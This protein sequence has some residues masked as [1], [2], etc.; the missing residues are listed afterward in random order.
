MKRLLLLIALAVF[1]AAS[2][3]AGPALRVDAAA[4][5][6]SP[7]NYNHYLA[8]SMCQSV[9]N[10]YEGIM[11][12]ED[13]KAAYP[14]IEQ[15]GIRFKTALC[16][17]GPEPKTLYLRPYEFAAALNLREL[18]DFFIQKRV[19]VYPDF[20]T[21]I[22]LDIWLGDY[23][24]T[25]ATALYRASLNDA[26][27][28]QILDDKFDYSQLMSGGT[29][30]LLM[31]ENHAG[32]HI[33][34]ALEV[35]AGLR[36]AGLTHFASEF[37]HKMQQDDIE[38]YR[39]SGKLRHVQLV[40]RFE[41]NMDVDNK[42][43]LN[44]AGCKVK[45]IALE[46]NKIRIGVD[47]QNPKKAKRIFSR[48]FFYYPDEF[49]KISN[50]LQNEFTFTQRNQDWALTI[51]TAIKDNKTA[52]LLGYMGRRHSRDVADSQDNTV[53]SILRKKGYKVK[54]MDIVG[55][56]RGFLGSSRMFKWLPKQILDVPF[57]YIVPAELVDYIGVDYILHLPAEDGPRG[58]DIQEY[59]TSLL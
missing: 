52:K 14:K 20:L 51:D 16:P 31:G 59:L 5:A 43:C 55:G 47:E 48:L 4:D 33:D 49:E 11:S 23:Y 39:Q 42:A 56:H 7:Q 10:V 26:R 37:L 45:T 19:P 40:K 13:F 12:I 30:I 24:P 18:T 2:Y 9:L 25:A 54:N 29:Q 6:Q 57:I 50:Q 1:T 32:N 58:A 15:K 53:T 35:I 44:A 46:E 41:L 3:A 36:D 17:I 22:P 21:G 8:L 38:K 27:H 28:I 34:G